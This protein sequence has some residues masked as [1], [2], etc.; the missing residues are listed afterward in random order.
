M[1]TLSQNIVTTY[2]R[3]TKCSYHILNTSILHIGKYSLLLLYGSSTK[4]CAL[5]R[6]EMTASSNI[7]PH[8]T[9][10]LFIKENKISK[11]KNY[12]IMYYRTRPH[13]HQNALAARTTVKTFHYQQTSPL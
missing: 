8:F 7:L 4:L 10:K 5:L 3:R 9:S 6:T 13:P 1:S 11:R 12:Y 2:E